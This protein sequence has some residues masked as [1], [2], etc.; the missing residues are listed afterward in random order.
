MRLLVRFLG[1]LFA[2]GT[3]LF[4][5][6]VSAVAGLLWHYSKD[7]PDYT[8]LK[9][10]EPPVM[11]RVHAADGSLLAEYAKERRLYLPIQ[12]IPKRV[13]NAFLAAEDK[14]FYEHGG[15]D[16]TG[17]ARAALLYA[18]NYGSN[19]R[20]QGAST[21]TQQVAKNFL[22]TNEV[23]FT[24]KIKEALLAMRIERT[25]SKEK[26][27][28][29]YLNEI[30]LGLGAY[31]IAAASL[32]YFDKS[33]N[34]LTV[35]EAAYLAALPKA[36]A[37]LHPVR[38]HARAVERRN[39]VIDRLAENGWIS[40]ADA[41]AARK[42]PLVVTSRSNATHIF[43]GEYF[44]EEVRRD[45]FERYGE[46]K[47]YEGGLSVRA[48]LDP[49]LQV[50]ARQAMVK[51]LVNYDESVG[52]R[53]P[54]TKI[55][56]SAGDWGVKLAEVKS[57]SDISPW[58][59]A[60]VLEAN[61][62][63]AR[64]GFQPGR[65]LGGAI[66]KDRETGLIT[67]D[68][69]RWAKAASGPTRYKA[70]TKVTQVLSP[71]D[72][73]YVD[74]LLGKD[75][76]VVEG[77]YRLRQIPDV[78]GGLIVMDPNTGRVLAMT[79]G[80][81]FD[82]SQ[83]NRA[84]QAYRQPGSSFKPIVYSTALDNGYTPSSIVVDAPIEID[85]GSGNVWRPENYSTG[86]YYGPQTLRF[87]LEHS[88]NNMTVRLAQD[89]GMPIIGEYAKRFGVYDELPNYLS[90]ALGAGETTVMR[91]VTAYSMIA[92]GGKRVKATLID[93]IQDRFGHTIYKHDQRECRGCDAPE[94]WHNQPEPTL[95][96]R[97]EQVLDP[98]TAYQITSM[99]EGV[100][101]RGTATV[102]R[103]VGKPIAG[104]TGT[105]NEEKDAWFVGFSPDVVVGLYIGYD[106]P[107][108]LG[109]GGTGGHL[110][111]PIAKDFLK[112]ALADK[113]AVPFRVPAGIKL[114][115]VDLK[116]G[117]R[118]GPGDSGR[119]ILEAFKPGTAPPDN[120]AAIGMAD[121]NGQVLTVSPD[122]DR[123]IMRPGTGGLY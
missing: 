106:K 109:R 99:M 76:K 30:Y 111:A 31:G 82:Q 87:G 16:F 74:P 91:M 46:K 43:A 52:W 116:S 26:I 73:V 123:A 7:L 80:F 85:Q 110:A 3:I 81:S 89:I 119:T 120:Y 88:V 56:L 20:P 57:L 13:I 118:A 42:E 61:D 83:F 32:V 121:G 10:Y 50:L 104:K 105:T 92:N 1:F 59:M 97:R 33:V 117:M 49:K 64:V 25:Y 14:N 51:G 75:G 100:V 90:Y 62:Q 23:S 48:T 84:T 5:V 41:Q 93:R 45:I 27:L 11:T 86:K 22:L 94:G 54:V 71:G 113:P 21:I 18:Q 63:S 69:V 115:R 66:S 12:A 98:M 53:G 60:V 58:R 77:Q 72:V 39:Y 28:E 37:Q 108:P 102:V 38:N 40:Q 114:V 101:Q 36:P 122:A 8:Q 70:P 6:G 96:D 35:A 107:K 95:I 15:I 47:L 44:A 4:L 24:R 68:G 67:M 9:N 78:S 79:G 112:V 19:R 2:A 17:M 29:L 103:E 34:E 65:V 55:D